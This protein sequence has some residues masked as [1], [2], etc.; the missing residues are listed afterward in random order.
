M[1]K[2]SYAQDSKSNL[3]AWLLEPDDPG[4]RYFALRDLLGRR[5]DDPEVTVA[6]QAI[7]ASSPVQAI[8]AAQRPDGGWGERLDSTYWPKYTATVWQMI[9]LS[10]LGLPGGHPAIRKGL[11]RMNAAIEGI[12][13]P[14]AIEEGEVLWC[15]SA[16]TIRYLWRFGL[17]D[18]PCTHAATERLVEAALSRP[19]W[20]CPHNHNTPCLWGAVKVLRAFAEV[21][22]HEWKSKVRQVVHKAA[23]PLLAHDYQADQ[24]K[25]QM[26]ENGWGTDWLK[27]G[28]PSFYESDLLEALDALA[29]VGYTHDPRVE[30]LLDLM[31]RKRDEQGRW[32]LENSFNGRMHVDIEEK[33]KPSKW[34]TLRAMRVL[35]KCY[36]DDENQ[37]DLGTL[38]SRNRAR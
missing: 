8:V 33:G 22:R 1:K 23:E 6:R 20:R 3:L 37:S 38:P 28:F 32:Q 17:G 30:P 10:E 27:F 24:V 7:P 14:T 34:V 16:N 2:H 11:H 12:G 21:P 35:E 4:I 18:A 19:E 15:Y 36:H 25:T 9:I 31:L 5:Q 29:A 13:A 26:T